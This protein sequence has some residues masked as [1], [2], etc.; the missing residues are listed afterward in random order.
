MTAEPWHQWAQ[1][2]GRRLPLL[3]EGDVIVLRSGDHYTQDGRAL[4]RASPA[5]WQIKQKAPFTTAQG[6][7]IADLMVG[8]FQDVYAVDTPGMITEES[9]NILL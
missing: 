5:N 8:A 3:E 7:S 9:L 1:D 2:L 6:F 4:Y